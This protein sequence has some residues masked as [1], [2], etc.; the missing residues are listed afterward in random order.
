MQESSLNHNQT[1]QTNEIQELNHPDNHLNSVQNEQQKI[2]N[3]FKMYDCLIYIIGYIIFLLYVIQ[4]TGTNI[5][6]TG[7]VFGLGLI[8]VIFCF[9]YYFMKQFFKK[10]AKQIKTTLNSFNFS[11]T[12][13]LTSLILSVHLLISMCYNSKELD[14]D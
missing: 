6:F 4:M 11:E 13:V 5:K 1:N 2:K 9:V 12:C 14:I 7:V 10:Y 8:A 3:K